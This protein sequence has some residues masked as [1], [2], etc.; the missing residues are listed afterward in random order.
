M[1]KYNE[2]YGPMI[3]KYITGINENKQNPP[4]KLPKVEAFPLTG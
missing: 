4:K 3:R 1:D 2:I